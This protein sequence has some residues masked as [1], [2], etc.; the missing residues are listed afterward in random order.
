[1]IEKLGFRSAKNS[2]SDYL[3]YIVT[4]AMIVAL[5]LSFNSLLF[6]KEIQEMSE[7]FGIMSIILLIATVFIVFIAAWLVNYMI[8]FSFQR[9]S[10][11]YAIYMLLGMKQRE[12]ARIYLIENLILSSIS[13]LAGI[14]VGLFVQQILMTIFYSMMNTAYYVSIRINPESL[15]LTLFCYAVC[16]LA[17]LLFNHRK[18][19]RMNIRLLMNQEKENEQITDKNYRLIKWLFPVSLLFILSF[20]IYVLSDNYT[21]AGIFMGSFLSLIAFYMFYAGLAAELVQSIRKRRAWIYKG[22]NLFVLRQLSS[23]IKTMRFTMGTL[24]ILFIC[25]FMGMSV[26]MMLNDWQNKQL[27]E[28]FPFDLSIHHAAPSYSFEKEKSEI[29]QFAG[30]S[31]SYTYSIYENHSTLFNDYFYT[32]LPVFGEKYTGQKN[33][34]PD[35]KYDKKYYRYDTFMK[36]SD[37][38]TLRSMLGYEKV[39]LAPDEYLLQVKQRITPYLDSVSDLVI[40]T[41]DGKLTFAGYKADAFCQ[42]GHNGADYLIIVPDDAADEMNLYYSQLAAMTKQPAAKELADHLPDDEAEGGM[43]AVGT[44]FIMY[45]G[46]IFIKSVAIPD[47]KYTLI[48]LY[49]PLVYIGLVFFCTALTVLSVQQLSHASKYRYRYE[50]LRKLGANNREIDLIIFKQQALFY[51]CPVLLAAVFSAVI[52]YSLSKK[53]I[54]STGVQTRPLQYLSISVIFFLGIY[55]LYFVATLIC[56]KRNVSLKTNV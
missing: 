51:L 18:F 41:G 49:F 28:N 40:P 3:I 48:L 37:Y 22:A 4:M 56:F 27:E 31:D 2:F 11:E 39:S 38:N 24:S 42:N 8:V 5:M 7:M 10:K 17:A 29:E 47:M 16:F 53:F 1:M 19:R 44:D 43:E 25:A 34:S 32:H 36:L 23:K 46:N 26:S 54:I 33:I 14:V 15:L 52:I 9:K 30:I 55:L 21:S 12:I 6:S 20:L 13:F 45:S 50:V 35:N